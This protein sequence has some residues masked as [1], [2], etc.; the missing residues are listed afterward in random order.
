MNDGLT[1]FLG[2]APEVAKVIA[3]PVGLAASLAVLPAAFSAA[4]TG[5]TALAGAVG[6]GVGGIGVYKA[7]EAFSEI[8]SQARRVSIVLEDQADGVR[9]WAEGVSSSFGIGA[10]S[11]TEAVAATADLLKPQGFNTAD[12][13]DYAT[14]LTNIGDALAKWG[15]TDFETALSALQAGL[16]GERESLKQ[17]GVVINQTEVDARAALLK[18]KG[19]YDNLNEAQLKTVATLELIEEKSTDALAAQEAG[20]GTATDTINALKATFDDLKNVAVT[21]FGGIITEI[22]GEVGQLSGL[23]DQLTAAP[24]ALRKWIRQNRE[25]IKKFFLDVTEAA[26]GLADATLT[27]AETIINALQTFLPILDKLAG[28]QAQQARRDAEEKRNV[29][30]AARDLA[31]KGVPG[32]ADVADR[33][34]READELER[35]ADAW[36]STGDALR[37]AN[38]NLSEY[39]ANFDNLRGVLDRLRGNVEELRAISNIKLNIKAGDVQAARSALDGLSKKTLIE[40]EAAIQPDAKNKVNKQLDVLARKRLIEIIA[41]QKSLDLT[42]KQIREL[43]RDR[44]ATITAKALTKAAERALDRAAGRPRYADIRMRFIDDGGVQYIQVGNKRVQVR[45]GR[46]VAP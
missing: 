15:G 23:G 33:L 40:L 24:E 4:A 17:F 31:N 10:A 6:V 14:E 7:L 32:Q 16:L 18:T 11:L 36:D 46:I 28:F 13:A 41:D 27:A 35:Q 26:L 5:I 39:Q 38:D 22:V 9:K 12:A 43:A 3:S 2:V 42:D 29:A 34:S 44:D 19:E 30:G 1:D 37:S 21:G 45:G 8:E 20:A 25:E